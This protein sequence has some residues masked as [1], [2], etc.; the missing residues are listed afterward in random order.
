MELNFHANTN[1]EAMVHDR[2]VSL[3]EAVSPLCRA[4]YSEF[5]NHATC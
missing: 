1:Q 5:T 2:G 3:Q 4:V